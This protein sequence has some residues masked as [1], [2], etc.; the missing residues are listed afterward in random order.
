[1]IS[2]SGAFFSMKSSIFSEKSKMIT[3][4]M[5]SPMAKKNVP[6]KFLIMYR[7]IFFTLF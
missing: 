5:I 7:S 6:K 3:I 1:M 2:F 4:R